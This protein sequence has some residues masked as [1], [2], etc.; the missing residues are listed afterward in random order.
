MGSCEPFRCVPQPKKR[1]ES[2]RSLRR[3][4]RKTDLN[5]AVTVSLLAM[6]IADERDRGPEFR[7]S[8]TLQGFLH[9]NCGD[10]EI[11]LADRDGPSQKRWLSNGFPKISVAP[12]KSDFYEH[13]IYVKGFS[14]FLS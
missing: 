6:Q 12:E 5:I 7:H 14:V 8:L 2:G 4:T 1:R 9:A 3:E 13:V 10:D 11:L